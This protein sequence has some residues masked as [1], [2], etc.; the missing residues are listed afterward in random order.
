MTACSPLQ[1]INICRR[2]DPGAHDVRRPAALAGLARGA[3]G[4]AEPGAVARGLRRR[5]LPRRPPRRIHRQRQ[6]PP[7]RDAQRQ[8]SGTIELTAS[9]GNYCESFTCYTS[10]AP[11]AGNILTFRRKNI[12]TTRQSMST[13]IGK[14]T[15]P[16][17]RENE[18][19]KLRSS[20]CCRRENST[21]YLLIFGAWGLWICRSLY[22]LRN[23]TSH[24]RLKVN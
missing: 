5:P 9:R 16:R 20:A 15:N 21:F 24:Q 1:S 7:P 14:S 19:K 4:A 8:D 11:R 13:G 18:V 12:G 10:R 17:F 3:D 22:S 2:P 23:Y 6:P